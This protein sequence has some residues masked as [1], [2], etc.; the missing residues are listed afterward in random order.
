MPGPGVAERVLGTR[1]PATPEA[2]SAQIGRILREVERCG[3]GHALRDDMA[4]VLGEV[5][6]NIVEHATTQRG[7]DWIEVDV[8]RSLG[9]LHVETVDGGTP[10]PPQLLSGAALPDFGETTHDLPEGGF[11]WFIIHSLAQ[12]MVY[13]REGG[14]NRLSFCFDE[15]R[16][17]A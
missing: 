16:E 12:D 9:R 4:I 14:R 7:D 6:N 17:I 1:F 2:V 3:I 10:L 8:T 5:L 11:G 15:V 13:E